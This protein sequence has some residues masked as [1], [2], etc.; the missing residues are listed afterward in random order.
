MAVTMIGY[1]ADWSK[2]EL[3]GLSTD[4]K[5]MIYKAGSSFFELDTKNAYL[6]DGVNWILM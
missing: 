4:T 6:Y 2:A 5:P 3:I 1:D